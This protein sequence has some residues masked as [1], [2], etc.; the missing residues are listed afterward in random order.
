VSP[1][2]LR[3]SVLLFKQN[4]KEGSSSQQMKGDMYKLDLTALI[5]PIR[6]PFR[7]RPFLSSEGGVYR[8]SK[9]SQCGVRGLS[10]RN[11]EM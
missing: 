4:E 7:L 3:P 11:L 6:I 2:S 9:I 1:R 5:P 10:E 8:A